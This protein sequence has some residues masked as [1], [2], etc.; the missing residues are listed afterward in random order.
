MTPDDNYVR[1]RDQSETIEHVLR[2]CYRVI[3]IWL[4]LVPEGRFCSF[5]EGDWET[6]LMNNLSKNEVVDGMDWAT[7]VEVSCWMLWSLRNKETMTKESCLY[8]TFHPMLKVRVKEYNYA[9]EMQEEMKLKGMRKVEHWI[10]WR[11]PPCGW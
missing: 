8:N 4:K 11:R 6:W 7:I 1:C 3:G 5:M 2:G 10:S 9:H